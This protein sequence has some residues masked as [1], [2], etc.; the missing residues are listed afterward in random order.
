MP[1]ESEWQHLRETAGAFA[2]GGGTPDTLLAAL[3]AVGDDPSPALAHARETVGDLLRGRGLPG[4]AADCYRAALETHNRLPL[5]D[6]AAV[7]RVLVSL[8]G[9]SE[10]LG[11]EADA[12]LCFEQAIPLLERIHGPAHT[13]LPTLMNNAG[14]LQR[15]LG[16]YPKSEA[17][18]DRALRLLES[19]FG[20]D[21][22]ELAP[23]YAQRRRRGDRKKRRWGEKACGEKAA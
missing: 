2:D 1:S 4:P 3:R 7:A 22:R 9:T 15:H 12:L 17:W 13:A 8:A 14:V 19:R 11:A 21:H 6:P 20:P 5:T 10:T 16:D 18:F 23:W